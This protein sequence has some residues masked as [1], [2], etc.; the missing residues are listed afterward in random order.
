MSGMVGF[1]ADDAERALLGACMTTAPALDAAASLSEDDFVAEPHRIVFRAIRG[2][3]DA[4]EPVDTLTVVEA[5]RAKGELEEAGGKPAVQELAGAVPVAANAAH[6]AKLVT[7]EANRRELLRAS[8]SIRPDL[9]GGRSPE[10]VAARL[11]RVAGDVLARGSA[12]CGGWHESA[13]DLLSE[14]DPGP[15]P[16]AIAELLV[17]NAIGAIQGPPKIGKTWLVLELALALVTGAPALG[18]F[19]VASPRPVLVVLEE[20]GRDALLRRL[21]ALIQARGLPCEALR[22]FHFAA[23][24]RVRLDDPEWCRRLLTDVPRLG[25]R[26][27]FLDPLVRLKGDGDENVQ[28]DMAPALDFMRELREAIEGPVIFVHHTPHDGKRLRGTSDLEGYWESKLSL[29]DKGNGEVELK[30]EH[31][32]AEGG[33][34]WRYRLR[35]GQGAS[36]T[37]ELSRSR[38]QEDE[39]AAHGEVWEWVRDHPGSSATE[40]VEGVNRRNQA[41]RETIKELKAGTDIGTLEARSATRRDKQGRPRTVETLHAVPAPSPA[42][43]EGGTTGDAE[44]TSPTSG[45]A[46][47]GPEQAPAGRPANGTSCEE[48]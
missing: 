21:H 4:G 27:V 45:P 36:I 7:E 32:E 8:E 33:N 2:L 23:N 37:L 34:S 35:R 22:D 30:A 48:R 13:A 14:G 40:V 28:K 11:Q 24:R 20:S 38:P 26:A 46:V 3:A 1:T 16:C 41:V 10:E 17:E 39:G 15:T 31:R 47:P 18:H 43:P 42:V 19:A 12:G 29:S 25:V 6:Y 9:V 44:P 5:L